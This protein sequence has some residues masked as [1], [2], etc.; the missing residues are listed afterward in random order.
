MENALVR[1]FFFEF[2]DLIR[3]KFNSS[4]ILIGFKI[5]SLS[6]RV[7]CN[8]SKVFSFSFLTC[9]LPTSPNN[10][11][12]S[13][14]LLSWPLPLLIKSISS[15]LGSRGRPLSWYG[16][17]S[18]PT[19]PSFDIENIVSSS[20]SLLDGFGVAESFN[21]LIMWG[22]TWCSRFEVGGELRKALSILNEGTDSFFGLSYSLPPKIALVPLCLKIDSFF[23]SGLISN[24]RS[25]YNTEWGDM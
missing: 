15:T 5:V 4:S 19:L 9:P 11:Q 12:A 3:S 2:K 18:K 13:S 6:T 25:S 7:W 10:R 22:N 1:S 23:H 14:S 8:S 21:F 16:L 17:Y 20:Y 24:W